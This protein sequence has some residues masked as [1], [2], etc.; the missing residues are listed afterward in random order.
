M[1]ALGGLLPRWRDVVLVNTPLYPAAWRA[2]SAWV[3]HGKKALA[4]RDKIL[5]FAFAT[6]SLFTGNEHARRESKEGN[7]LVWQY[8]SASGVHHARLV[9]EDEEACVSVPLTISQ[10]QYET[11]AESQLCSS[12]P[13]GS[14]ELL[15]IE[16]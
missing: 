5:V 1:D 11:R 13:M 7:R 6:V 10:A 8:A 15:S 4:I 3:Y 16:R 14:C 12:T 2:G 9:Y